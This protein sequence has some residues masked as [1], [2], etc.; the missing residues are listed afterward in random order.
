MLTDLIAK[1]ADATAMLWQA[2]DER[3]RV[4]V[5]VGASYLLTVL[6]TGAYRAERARH[7]E[8]LLELFRLELAALPELERGAR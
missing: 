5:L 3:E 8:R 1:A 7:D 4:L 6:L 2:L